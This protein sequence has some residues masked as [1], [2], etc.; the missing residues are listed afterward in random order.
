MP[1]NYSEL[2]D[3]DIFVMPDADADTDIGNT[4][5]NLLIHKCRGG[6]FVIMRSLENVY[7]DGC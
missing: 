2:T 4:L 5:G 3:A 6:S 7:I 1:N